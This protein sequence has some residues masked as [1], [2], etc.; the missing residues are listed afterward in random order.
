MSHSSDLRTMDEIFGLAFQTNAI[1]VDEINASGTGYNYVAAVNDLSDLFQPARQ[2]P[3][4]VG[5]ANLGVG[6][7]QLTL[8]APAGQTYQVLASDDPN[9]PRSSWIVL[10]TGTFSNTNVVFIDTDAANHPCRFY[11]LKSP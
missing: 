7:I 3:A 4:F 8:S 6:G 5:Q 9:A 2:A 11:T 10:E 1:P